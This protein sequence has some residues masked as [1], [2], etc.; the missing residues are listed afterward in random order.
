MRHV[1]VDAGPSASSAA[2]EVSLDEVLWDRIQSL[3]V[4]ARRF[5]EAVAVS[6]QPIRQSSAFR[7]AGLGADGLASLALLR[8]GHLVRSTGP[9]SL[10]HLEVYHDRIRETVIKHLS[11]EDLNAWHGELARELKDAG[12]ADAETLA[13]HF[14][15]AGSA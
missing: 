8:A 5:L 12:G 2:R 7:V 9:R 4:G 13:V 14:E 6:G 1:S 11:P 15:A 3:P 10:E